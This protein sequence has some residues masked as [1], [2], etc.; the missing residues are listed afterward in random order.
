MGQPSKVAHTALVWAPVF[1]RVTFSALAN[2]GS[3]RLDF[4][5]LFHFGGA[6]VFDIISHF[7][8]RISR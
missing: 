3:V 8:H 2:L 7:R 1:S 6:L 5:V 4:V